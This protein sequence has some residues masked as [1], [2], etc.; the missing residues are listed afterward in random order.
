MTP[1]IFKKT[2][3]GYL[4][5]LWF[6]LFVMLEDISLRAMH[7]A[8]LLTYVAET[9]K[10]IKGQVTECL[11]PIKLQVERIECPSGDRVLTNAV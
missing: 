3:V 4:S 8:C 11:C 7:P 2:E 9:W 10:M 6:I 5:E 1:E